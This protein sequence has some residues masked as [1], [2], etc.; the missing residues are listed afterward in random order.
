MT[1]RGDIIWEADLRES[2]T[3]RGREDNPA[4]SCEISIRRWSIPARREGLA[5]TSWA[6]PPLSEDLGHAE[7]PK[8]QRNY[9]QAAHNRGRRLRGDRFSNHLW[10]KPP[11]EDQALPPDVKTSSGCPI[12]G[13]RR[14]SIFTSA[15]HWLGPAP[16]AKE[17]QAWITVQVF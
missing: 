6:H 13:D 5:A 11:S 8:R 7:T 16:R 3:L 9:R 15:Q 2:E 1:S 14:R 17:K 12:D 4:L 10:V